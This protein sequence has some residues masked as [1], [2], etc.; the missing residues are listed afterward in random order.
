MPA[1][2]LCSEPVSDPTYY[3][4][5]QDMRDWDAV[6]RDDIDSDNGPSIPTQPAKNS[7]EWTVVNAETK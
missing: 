5:V 7:D 1:T 6:Y 4:T 3:M 2:I